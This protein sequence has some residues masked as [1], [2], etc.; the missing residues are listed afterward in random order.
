MKFEKFFGKTYNILFLQFNMNVNLC[1][2]TDDHNFYKNYENMDQLFSTKFEEKLKRSAVYFYNYD[3]VY[4]IKNDYY[5]EEMPLSDY[6]FVFFGFVKKHTTI[7]TLLYN[8]LL[9]NN[10]PTLFFGTF[11]YIQNKAYDLELIEK[12]KYPY[13]PSILTTKINKSIINYIEDNFKYPVI[14]K[15]IYLDNGAGVFKCN[16]KKELIKK[17]NSPNYYFNNKLVLIQKFVHNTGDYRVILIKGKVVLCVKKEQPNEKEFRNNIT[18]GAIMVKGDL[19]NNVLLMCESISKHVH[20][21]IIGIDIIFDEIDKKYYV[22]EINTAPG[23]IP[24]SI[25]AGVDVVDIIID[26]II[27]EFKISSFKSDKL[28]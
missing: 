16:S 4:K 25:S 10:I 24:F 1:G 20:C 23:F 13:I 7:S 21:D 2:L 9:N 12:L 15:N 28:V 18:N 11:D 6:D 3:D 17:I 14:V 22:M 26:Y 8:Y 5:V 27:S 19:P